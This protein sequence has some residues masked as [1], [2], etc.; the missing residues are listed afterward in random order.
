MKRLLRSQV[1]SELTA[2]RFIWSGGFL[3]LAACTVLVLKSLP[4]FGIW[5]SIGLVSCVALAWLI[6]GAQFPRVVR[7]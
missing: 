4:E 2:R 1:A 7:V 6:I 3:L 5:S